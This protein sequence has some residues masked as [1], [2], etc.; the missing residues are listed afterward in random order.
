MEN[1]PGLRLVAQTNGHKCY[2]LP[3]GRHFVDVHEY[4]TAVSCS[5]RNGQFHVREHAVWNYAKVPHWSN[6][7]EQ[8]KELAVKRYPKQIRHKSSYVR[9]ERWW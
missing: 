7:V 8:F 1:I 9:Q 5:V 2:A 6:L 4:S 3:D